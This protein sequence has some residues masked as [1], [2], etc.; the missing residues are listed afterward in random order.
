MA[1][2]D[3]MTSHIGNKSTDSWTDLW[4][5][6]SSTEAPPNDRSIDEL[7]DVI[8]YANFYCIGAL[9]VIGIVCNVMSMGVFASSR[10]LRRTT[11][12]HYLIALSAADLL[13]LL[14]ETLKWL[15]SRDSHDQI[16]NFAFVS[17]NDALCKV[18]NDAK[19]L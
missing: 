19:F 8:Y 14:G 9:V 5:A 12:G 3:T 2:P 11:T 18:C 13:Y 6:A 10:S 16:V 4:D 7:L 17:T 15:N 1:S